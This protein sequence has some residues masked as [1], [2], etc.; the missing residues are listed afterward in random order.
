[1]SRA[2][3]VDIVLA[4]ILNVAGAIPTRGHWPPGEAGTPTPHMAGS[5]E[6]RWP[7]LPC[8]PGLPE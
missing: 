6:Q 2:F 7:D 5:F 4:P 3:L 8:L 1:M